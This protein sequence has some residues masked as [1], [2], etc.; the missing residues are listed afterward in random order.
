VAQGPSTAAA[1]DKPDH[2]QEAYVIERWAKKV[3][4]QN[5]GTL[6]ADSAMRVRVQS[7]AG[8]KHFGVLNFPYQ[9]ANERHEID[10]VRV[11]KPDGKEVRTPT[12]NFQDLPADVTRDAPFYS[13]LR[14]T[15]V[16]VRGLSVGDTLEYHVKTLV[17]TPLVPGHFW[18]A[19]DFTKSVIVLEEELEVSVPRDR[20]VKTK[21]A[22]LKPTVIEEGDRR[23]FRWKSSNLGR[24]TEDES[25]AES[26]EPAPPAVQL[27]TFQSFEEVGRW[28]DSLQRDRVEPTPEIRAKAAYLTEG[29]KSDEEKVKAL[30][31][32]VSLSFRY[33]GIAFGVG[34]Y[35]PNAA[36]DVL[37]NQYGD[38]KDKHTLLA[39]LLKAA[40]LTAHAALINATRKTD[41]DV[42]SPAQFD[43]VIT[44]VPHGEN[45]VWLDTTAE[46][47]PFGFL[48]AGL[49]DKQALVIP[50]GKSPSL[51]NV[52]AA[53]PSPALSASKWKGS[54]TTPA[55][56]RPRLTG[57]CVAILR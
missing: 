48:L 18:M 6:T 7:D 34:R 31:N 19:H 27:T 14:E 57:G 15:H 23:I 46:V 38:C 35:Q 51:V 45:Y 3:Q 12:E 21:F 41:I 55:R 22:H 36:A 2:S 17:H 37:A 4:F 50:E 28:Y 44:A 56:S 54:S 10:I 49:R 20:A 8:V 24:K 43:H 40:G 32:Y 42:P 39:A 25:K 16:A 26:A 52:P 47:A 5:D 53:P 11:I 30:Y 29:A 13:D 1:P 33:I 9:Q